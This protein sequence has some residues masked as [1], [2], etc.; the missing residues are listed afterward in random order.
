MGLSDKFSEWKGRLSEAAAEA[1][2]KAGEL[3]EQA[4]ESPLG[5]QAGEAAR[6]ARDRAQEA[7]ENFKN[8]RDGR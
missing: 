7:Y 6:N 4:K 8:E 1:Q 3:L 5:E 2:G